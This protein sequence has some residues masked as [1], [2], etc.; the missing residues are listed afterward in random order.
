MIPEFTSVD[1][2]SGI[3]AGFTAR[4]GGA[5]TEPYTSLNLGA[6]VG[7]NPA[8]VAHNRSLVAQAVGAPVAFAEQVH[9]ANVIAITDEAPW[10]NGEPP[11]SAGQGDGLVTTGEIGLGVLVA[12]CVP[13]LLASDAVVATAHA[14]RRGIELGV[15]GEVVAAMRAFSPTYHKIRAAIGPAICGRCYEVPAEMR[16]EVCRVAPQAYATTWTGTAGLDLPAAALIQ[17]E[18]AGVQV[19]YASRVCT[20]ED[21]RY[22]SHRRATAHG[23]T[24]GRQAGIVARTHGG[25]LSSISNPRYGKLAAE[26][27]PE[28]DFPSALPETENERILQT[29]MV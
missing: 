17:L 10:R 8:I 16:D 2:G 25:M 14:G 26:V 11:V 27:T 24:T 19:V 1:L 4:A 28:V 18:A 13:I 5:S 7:D 6:N 23:T 29:T 9:G 12:D 22:Y 20:M 3:F 15:I 21:E